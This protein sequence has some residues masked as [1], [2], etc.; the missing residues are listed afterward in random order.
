MAQLFD[1]PLNYGGGRRQ[2]KAVTGCDTIADDL[3]H[4]IR[5]H[6]SFVFAPEYN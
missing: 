4:F 6:K 1:Y 3:I 2:Y 5:K